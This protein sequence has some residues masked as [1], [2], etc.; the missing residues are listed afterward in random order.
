MSLPFPPSPKGW[1]FPAR[2]HYILGELEKDGLDHIVSWLPHGKGF[3]VHDPQLLE[4]E[5][6][7]R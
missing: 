2:L 5:I 7:P 1:S 4:T 3:K 6:L